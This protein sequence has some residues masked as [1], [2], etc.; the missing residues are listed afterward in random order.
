ME[1]LKIAIM[2]EIR[3]LRS[4][5]DETFKI[6]LYHPSHGVLYLLSD[7]FWYGPSLFRLT[8]LTGFSRSF[9]ARDCRH[10]AGFSL[11]ILSRFTES[12]G[13][14]GY[15]R[16]F[17]VCIEGLVPVLPKIGGDLYHMLGFIALI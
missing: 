13:L 15:C 17:L 1:S 8:F 5:S 4:F 6:L 7:L 11:Q 3:V 9:Q 2:M 14:L 12:F 16:L 10:H